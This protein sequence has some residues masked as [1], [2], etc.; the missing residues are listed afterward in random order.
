MQLSGKILHILPIQSGTSKK[1]DWQ[2]RDIVIE[3]DGE[4]PKNVCV[5]IWNKLLDI[6]LSE[7]QSITADIDINAKEYNTKW[8]NEVKAWKIDVSPLTNNVTNSKKVV[9]EIE[10]DLP[11]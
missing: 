5:S 10:A 4:Y 3:T 6:K 1:G 11:F 7:G 8:Y 9:T 2:K